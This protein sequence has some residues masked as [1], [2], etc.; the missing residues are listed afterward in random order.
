MFVIIH[1][2]HICQSEKR[3]TSKMC[4][5]ARGIP[6]ILTQCLFSVYFD[7]IPNVPPLHHWLCPQSPSSSSSQL[8]CG[9]VYRGYDRHLSPTKYP[10]TLCFRTLPPSARSLATLGFW[11]PINV[12]C[13]T[14]RRS[15][16]CSQP[17]KPNTEGWMSASTTQALLI[18]TVF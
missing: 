10:P 11:F 17:S 5:H 16:P 7:P 8:A 12:T 14:R 1:S 6:F 9:F 3:D 18:Q 15:L 4:A 13:P 2:F